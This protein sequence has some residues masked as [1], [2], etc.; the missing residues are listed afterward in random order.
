[1]RIEICK[2]GEEQHNSYIVP[3]ALFWDGD[4]LPLYY[5]DRFDEDPIGTF[6]DIRVEDNALTGEI[7]FF[8]D[9]LG[10]YVEDASYGFYAVPA[11]MHDY[12]GV[13]FVTSGYVRCAMMALNP[14]F[15]ADINAGD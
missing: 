6:S 1:M 14:V 11:E 3:G 2:I 15:P 12:K 10:E 4:E 7:K 5:G 8:E 13:R 9:R